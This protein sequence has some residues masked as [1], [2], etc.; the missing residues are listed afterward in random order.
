MAVACVHGSDS[1]CDKILQRMRESDVVPTVF[2][3]NTLLDRHASR[4]NQKEAFVVIA[5]MAQAGIA[6]DTTT[7]NTL[8]KLCV[9]RNDVDGAMKVMLDRL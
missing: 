9:N 6:A 7:Y 5:Q 4:R 3:Y 1:D 8:L 2:T